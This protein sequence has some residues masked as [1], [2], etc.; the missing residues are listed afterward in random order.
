LLAAV[1]AQRGITSVQMAA[2]AVVVVIAHRLVLKILVAD[3]PQ[4]H[5]Y[6]HSL[7]LHTRSRLVVAALGVPVEQMV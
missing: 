5:V 2:V 7:A 1:V 4:N 3:Y 6:K